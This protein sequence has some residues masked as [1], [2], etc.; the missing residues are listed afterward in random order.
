MVNN[1]VNNTVYTVNNIVYSANIIVYNIVFVHCYNLRFCFVIVTM[2]KFGFGI[3]VFKTLYSSFWLFI[4]IVNVQCCNNI[5]GGLVLRWPSRL[6][7]ICFFTCRAPPNRAN[8]ST[9]VAP[10]HTQGRHSRPRHTHKADRDARS[11][12]EATSG[13]LGSRLATDQDLEQAL[14]S[15][16]R[17]WQAAA[18][19]T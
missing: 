7:K 2:S 3:V 15:S 9:V 16:V 13:P 5:V 19:A 6:S 1:N 12:N 10:I 4:V 11:R 17:R 14:S 8:P 18:C